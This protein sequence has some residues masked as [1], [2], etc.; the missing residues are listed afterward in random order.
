MCTLNSNNNNNNDDD[1]HN[2]NHNHD[3]NFMSNNNI[4]NSYGLY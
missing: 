2:H 4:L 1:N 3:K